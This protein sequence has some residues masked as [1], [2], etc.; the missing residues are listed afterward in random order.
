[1]DSPS[2]LLKPVLQYSDRFSYPLTAEEIW[3]WQ[4]KST[5][6]K[7][8]VTKD[9]SSWPSLTGYYYL[10]RST[11]NLRKSRLIASTGKW[12]KAAAAAKILQHVPTI[13]AIFVTGSLAM[14]NSPPDDDIDFMIVTS[15]H[16]LWL[17]RLLVIFTLSLKNLRR[18]PH[19]PEH[20]SPAVSD[21]ICDNLYL[22]SKS[23][24]I[25]NPSLYLA[26]EI[27]QAKCIFDRS[28]IHRQFLEENSWV[29]DFL[30]IAYHQTI[31]N[32]PNH[33]VH[34][35]FYILNLLLFP[36]NLLLFTIQYLY[37]KPHITSERVS[38]NYA[39]FHPQSKN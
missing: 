1:M 33:I 26:H 7:K 20:S 24:M 22:S 36:I 2:L 16:T 32:A 5:F 30:P 9:I 6:T 27:L 17:T 31:S 39:F 13:Q 34:S 14:S 25:H 15:P 28:N 4:I 37:M 23:L 3:F 38:L 8:Q 18:P 19:L 12:Q 21:K 29:G 35:T 10:R 11:V